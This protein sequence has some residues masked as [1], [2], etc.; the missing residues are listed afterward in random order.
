VTEHADCNYEIEYLRARVASAELVVHAARDLISPSRT[1][2]E[3]GVVYVVES[4]AAFLG[5]R[6]DPSRRA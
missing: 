1:G 5:N 6:P 4:Y 3:I 2:S